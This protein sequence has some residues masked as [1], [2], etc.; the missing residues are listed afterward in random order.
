[1]PKCPWAAAA[2][3]IK[4]NLGSWC[5]QTF[6][7][8]VSC[9]AKTW[10]PCSSSV[11]NIH[12]CLVGPAAPIWRIRSV[13]LLC[14]RVRTLQ[15]AR[16]RLIITPW[17]LLTE[18]WTTGMTSGS[19]VVAGLAGKCSVLSAAETAGMCVN[20]IH[21]HS[22]AWPKSFTCVWWTKG[23]QSCRGCPDAAPN[24]IWSTNSFPGSPAWLGQNR[25]WMWIPNCCSHSLRMLRIKWHAL[26]SQICVNPVLNH[27]FWRVFSGGC[28]YSLYPLAEHSDRIWP[29]CKGFSNIWWFS[30]MINFRSVCICKL[31]VPLLQYI[32]IIESL[33]INNSKLSK[34]IDSD[35]T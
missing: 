3:W 18:C 13:C 10:M 7:R 9:K 12:S 31:Y 26:W 16:F 19:G 22:I 2:L 21:A 30:T 28:D 8:R 34:I 6:L 24:A 20:S 4:W 29:M 33:L 15:V 35:C 5:F 23:V 11:S 1:M 14:C 25:C 32:V 27:T 17:G